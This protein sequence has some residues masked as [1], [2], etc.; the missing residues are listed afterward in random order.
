MRIPTEQFENVP[1]STLSPN[2]SPRDEERELPGCTKSL[3]LS[4]RGSLTPTHAVNN[5]SALRRNSGGSAPISPSMSRKS[6][7]TDSDSGGQRSISPGLLTEDEE[8]D[9]FPADDAVSFGSN[10]PRSL[11]SVHSISM[12]LMAIKR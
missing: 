8:R 9:Q 2:I 11:P 1:V 7:G 5:N 10:G 4:S 6:G 12:G 3:T